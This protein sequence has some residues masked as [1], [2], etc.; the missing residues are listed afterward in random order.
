MICR[1][2]LPCAGVLSGR[3]CLFALLLR[4]ILSY[5]SMTTYDLAQRLGD[6]DV[7]MYTW[8]SLVRSEVDVRAERRLV[9][10]SYPCPYRRC[11]GLFVVHLCVKE[12]TNDHMK[13][14]S[15]VRPARCSF[16]LGP[17][18]LPR[19]DNGEESPASLSF[20]SS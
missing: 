3:A 1:V 18:L 15:C 11:A 10:S 7:G 2:G 17:I 4:C 12:E 6:G 9:A 20:Y 5:I 19:L 8:A 16:L 13:P 14:N